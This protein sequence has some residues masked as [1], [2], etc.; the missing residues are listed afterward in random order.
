[1]KAS[2]KDTLTEFLVK[3]QNMTADGVASLFV[4]N[5]EEFDLKPEFLPTVTQADA[6]RVKA[7][8]DKEEAARTKG[9]DKAKAET[10]SKFETDVKAKYGVESDKTGIELFEEI[11]AA[12]A[13]APA[14][15][16]LTLEK[17]KLD[18]IFQAY[19]KELRKTHTEEVT[20]AKKQ[21]EDYKQTIAEEKT[22]SNI[23]S[24]GVQIFD[25]LK[26]ILSKDPAKAAIQKQK[27]ID[28]IKNG[29]TY[30]LGEDG[31]ITILKDGK[32]HETEHG[33]PISFETHVKEVAGRFFDFEEGDHHSSTGASNTGKPGAT[34]T[35]GA[36]G[37]EWKGKVPENDA[38]YERLFP[39]LNASDRSAMTKAYSAKTA[40]K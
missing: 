15:G 16:K 26:P 33:K 14:E 7:F 22:F 30:Q 38:E 21:F 8:K 18:P 6:T 19:E 2:E 39:T 24:K 25:A 36:A 31:D 12:K 11:L 3:T 28:D 9:Y 35:P 5:G 37:S 4:E 32:R 13:P 23:A 20:A 27:F 1:M 29:F 10:L 40:G 17:M 34:G